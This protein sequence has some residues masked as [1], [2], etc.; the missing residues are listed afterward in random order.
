MPEDEDPG[1]GHLDEVPE[2]KT[3]APAMIQL[4]GSCLFGTLFAAAAAALLIDL[5]PKS[6]QLALFLV[7]FA[8]LA[9][10]FSFFGHWVFVVRPEQITQK[11]EDED[12]SHRLVEND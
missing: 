1:N 8:V 2:R 7:L 9:P 10:T 6:N 12:R 5:R 4:V 3:S 11:L